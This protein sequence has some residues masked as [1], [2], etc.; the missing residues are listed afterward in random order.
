MG[1]DRFR[2]IRNRIHAAGHKRLLVKG[3][4][5]VSRLAWQLKRI[6]EIELD[7]CLNFGGHLKI[8][9]VILEPA[10]VERILRHPGL[11]ARAPFRVPAQTFGRLL[12]CG[13]APCPGARSRPLNETL[14]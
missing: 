8:V 14:C 12:D 5:R 10:V 6:F 7:H 3:C 1:S 9:A 4:S 2:F 11:H 13:Q